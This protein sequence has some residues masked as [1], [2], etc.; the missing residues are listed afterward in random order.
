ML[1][2]PERL[3]SEIVSG[4]CVAFVGAGFSATLVPGW[5]DLLRELAGELDREALVA[6]VLGDRPRRPR[7]DALEAAAQ[8]LRDAD[9]E[10]FI[11][12]LR[13]RLGAAALRGRSDPD[14]RTRERL[15][16]LTD[17][18]F[19][20]ILT[21]NFDGLLAGR[22]PCG[23]VYWSALRPS[24][25]RWWDARFWD[26]GARGPE[27]VKLHGDVDS[28][29][30]H[31]LVF[32]R[33]DY[34]KRLYQA[35]S[36]TSFL[37]SIM[38]RFTVLYLGFSFSDA[39]V[40]ELRS[41]VLALFGD[42]V[43]EPIAYAVLPNVPSDYAEYLAA[44]EG[45]EVL[46]YEH[47]ED[48]G[49]AGFDEWLAAIHHQTSPTRQ[50]GSRLSGRR[51]LWVDPEPANNEYGDR[52]LRAAAEEAPGDECVIDKVGTWPEAIDALA[53][54]EY[55]L[56]ITHWG[57]DKATDRGGARCPV[58]ERLLVEMRSRDLRAP[59]LVFSTLDF[60]DLNKVAALRLGARAYIFRWSTLFREIASVFEPGS[61]DAATG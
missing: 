56:V 36:Y 50:L 17:V 13:G 6:R 46:G 49:H 54:V 42:R 60:A 39:Y 5:A 35:A 3:R 53:A 52:F 28:D 21:T 58:G 19:A 44:H 10:A 29:G 12:A 20:S 14:G 55:D 27:V 45:I 33:R 31:E 22:P 41:E 26:R 51:L 23:E 18:P 24:A 57:W 38:A 8:M 11:A 40:N 43:E 15:R 2:V 32:S 61:A 47:R 34:R 59:V 7:S 1:V 25:H 16:L 48:D 37:R 4:N 30:A 9:P